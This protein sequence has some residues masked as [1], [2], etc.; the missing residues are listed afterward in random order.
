MSSRLYLFAVIAGLS[1]AKA[2]AADDPSAYLIQGPDGSPVTA[3]YGACVHTSAWVSGMS[4]RQCDPA[5]VSI[6]M[7]AVP[8]V[9]KAAPLEAAPEP[10]RVVAET[11]A[12][13]AVPF[14][15]SMDALFDFDSAILRT[16][17]GAA[18][19]QLG[20]QIAQADYRSI[21][22]VGHAD[23][24]GRAKY[25]QQL[26]E[27]RA[28]AVREYLVAHGTDGSKIAVSGVGSTEPVTGSNCEGMRGKLL[29]SC[30][31][32]DR[33]ADVKVTGTQASAMR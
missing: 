27:A 14:R 17:A 22:I 5:P 24:I 19:D 12:P 15:V 9:T 25:N 16:D 30:L 26:S 18:L 6:E 33:Y 29:I 10:V 4:Y 20:K 21:D 2:Q 32:P 23:R 8:P 3:G 28:K 11:P 13:S 7:P 31:Q 1:V